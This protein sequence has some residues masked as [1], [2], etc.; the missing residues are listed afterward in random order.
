MGQCGY[1]ACP[2]LFPLRKQKNLPLTW[3]RRCERV[4]KTNRSVA[5]GH[6]NGSLGVTRLAPFLEPRSDRRVSLG[7]GACLALDS[8][9]LQLPPRQPPLAPIESYASGQCPFGSARGEFMH[10]FG[11]TTGTHYRDPDTRTRPRRAWRSRDAFACSSA[12]NSCGTWCHGLE[13]NSVR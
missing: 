12:R 1:L 6:A 8:R 9:L 11:R 4:H 5:D 13:G 3:T 7:R 10:D 2:G